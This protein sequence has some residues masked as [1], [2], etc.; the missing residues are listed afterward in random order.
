[1]MK[2]LLISFGLAVAVG[3]T[4]AGLWPRKANSIRDCRL[5]EVTLDD[6]VFKDRHGTERQTSVGV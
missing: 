6:G 4:G 3:G 1:M 2:R 5:Q